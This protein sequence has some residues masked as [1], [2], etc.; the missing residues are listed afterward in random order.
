M[1]C[2]GNVANP[3]ILGDQYDLARALNESVSFGLTCKARQEALVN[4]V[5]VR[6]QILK[7]VKAQL[8]GAK[9]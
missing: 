5:V 6:D 3:L 1:K 9:P 4:A 8:E 2:S 7:S